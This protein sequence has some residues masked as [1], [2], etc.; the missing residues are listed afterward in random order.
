MAS[1]RGG[2]TVLKDAKHNSAE[3]HVHRDQIVTTRQTKRAVPESA[4]V[5]L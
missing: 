4:A 1:L 5:I 3:L 2:P